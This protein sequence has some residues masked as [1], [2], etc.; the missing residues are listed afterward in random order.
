MTH[1]DIDSSTNPSPI[2]LEGEQPSVEIEVS[3]DGSTL[4]VNALDGSCTGRFSKRFGMDVHHTGTAMMA[5]QGECLVC[6]HEPAG[7]AE[8]DI[9]RAAMKRHH[10]TDVPE[11]AITFEDVVLRA[12]MS[13]P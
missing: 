12:R 1:I 7:P 13:R 8:W 9:F 4:W 10:D 11:D 5:G 2:E 3:G 6:T